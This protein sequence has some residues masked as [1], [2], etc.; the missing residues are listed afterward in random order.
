MIIIRT[1]IIE[2]ENLMNRLLFLL[3]VIAST[4]SAVSQ[5]QWE[6]VTAASNP[7]KPNVG[8]ATAVFAFGD[9]VLFLDYSQDLLF[10]ST[11]SGSSWV[12]RP[13]PGPCKPMYFLNGSTGWV[14]KD[15]NPGVMYKTTNSGVSWQQGFT[16]SIDMSGPSP[17]AIEFVSPN[18]GYLIGKNWYVYKTTDG[19]NTFFS[20][21]SNLSSE[22]YYALSFV[23]ENVGWVTGHTAATPINANVW[24]TTDGGVTWDT[25][26][27]AVYPYNT[28]QQAIDALNTNHVWCGGLNDGYQLF[29]SSNAGAVFQSV[30]VDTIFYTGQLQL[31]STSEIWGLTDG[32]LIH[33][34]TAGPPFQKVYL[35]GSPLLRHMYFQS[36][37]SGWVAAGAKVWHYHPAWVGSHIQ[38]YAMPDMNTPRIRARM[39][40]LNNEVYVFGGRSASLPISSHASTEKFIGSSWTPAPPMNQARFEF[41]SADMNSR[42]FVFGGQANGAPLTSVESF[43]GTAWTNDTPLPVALYDF[44]GAVVDGVYYSFGGIMNVGSGSTQMQFDNKVRSFSPSTGWS[45]LDDIPSLSGFTPRAGYTCV[46]SDSFVYIIGGAHASTFNGT[47]TYY[48][49]VWKY[50]PRASLNNRL[51]QVLSMTNNRVNFPAIVLDGYIYAIGGAGNPTAIERSH[52]GITSWTPVIDQPN[53]S[54][55]S[56]AI[57]R[58]GAGIYLCGINSAQATKCY[59]SIPPWTP[60]ELVSFQAHRLSRNH[61]RL[62]W[63]TTTEQNNLG[64]EVQRRSE[65]EI[66]YRTLG[67][68][69]GQCNSTIDHLY[70]YDDVSAPLSACVYRLK[71]QDLDGTIS[72]SDEVLLEQSDTYTEPSLPFFDLNASPNP[73]TDRTTLS[74]GM[75]AAED[76]LIEVYDLLGRMVAREDLGKMARGVHHV[77]LGSVTITHG[78]YLVK[79]SCRTGHKLITLHKL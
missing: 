20:V 40:V 11:N 25:Q 17:D 67:F 36:S 70:S 4:S 37:D 34:T 66:S 35:P 77:S 52:F 15:A 56:A 9:T 39:G 26:S 59:S 48:S 58:N 12:S 21:K 28:R 73:F 51:S 79:L 65:D 50:D 33:T 46:A 14:L 74:F 64:F 60:V 3:L 62:L 13:V 63:T 54:V 7:N 78:V 24:R 71:Q 2:T 68:V 1:W 72:Y 47:I 5:S 44:D 16:F 18:V 19:G 32:F 22:S 53:L 30:Q 75:I 10:F 69:A 38:W 61:V 41:S 42:I 43:N 23:N 55:E 29:A 27:T 8:L 57:A 49:D 76:V 31:L 6:D 45:A